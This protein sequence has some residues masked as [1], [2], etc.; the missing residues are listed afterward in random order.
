MVPFHRSPVPKET[1]TSEHPSAFAQELSALKIRDKD[2]DAPPLWARGLTRRDFICAKMEMDS[3]TDPDMLKFLHSQ[4]PST[5]AEPQPRCF[6][7]FTPITCITPEPD[8]VEK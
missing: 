7:P 4:R 2:T 6:S 5:S 1:S 8:P 3:S